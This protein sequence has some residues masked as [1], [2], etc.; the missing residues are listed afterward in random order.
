MYVFIKHAFYK[1]GFIL[2]K[3]RVYRDDSTDNQRLTLIFAS[4]T[5]QN[6]DTVVKTQKLVNWRGY[7]TVHMNA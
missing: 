1:R 6:D 2:E 7:K 3:R 5:A 4:H